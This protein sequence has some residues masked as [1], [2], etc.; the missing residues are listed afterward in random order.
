[1]EGNLQSW[2][3]FTGT[4]WL[5]AD[6]VE[7][8]NMAYAVVSVELEDKEEPR[9]LLTI[10]R[11]EQ[12][13][14]FTLNITNANKCKELGVKH[15]QDLVGKK[16]YFKKVLVRDPSSNKEVEGLRIYQIA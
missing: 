2:D 13:Y 14:K 12:S 7:N 16:I 11:K 10:E 15:P 3:D 1:M 9:P 8:E 6:N 5:K 4:Q